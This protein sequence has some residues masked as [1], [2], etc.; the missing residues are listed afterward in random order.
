M[1][2]RPLVPTKMTAEE[3]LKQRLEDQILWYDRRSQQNQ[4]WYKR[5][6]L[7][8]FIAAGMIPFLVGYVVDA[9]PWLPIIIGALGA[10]VAVIAA[11]LGL[12][13]FEQ[14]WIEYRTTCESLKKEKYLYLTRT[15]PFDDDEA[16]NFQLLVQRVETLVSK[17]NTNWA[18]YMMRPGEEQHRG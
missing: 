4:N 11:V 1:H 16:D 12:Y 7:V 15:E 18:Q 5:L 8:E 6:R 14:N 17:E 9:R 13:Q 10:L 3:Y 2:E